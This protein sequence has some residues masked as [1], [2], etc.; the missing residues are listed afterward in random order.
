MSTP[1]EMDEGVPE[2]GELSSSL[3]ELIPVPPPVVSDSPAP[4]F[5]VSVMHRSSRH[6]GVHPYH[7][8]AVQSLP[9]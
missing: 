8:T 9:Q 6:C 3:E 1:S 4:D 2:V 5:K 7:N